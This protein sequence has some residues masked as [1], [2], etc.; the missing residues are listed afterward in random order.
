M[1]PAGALLAGKAVHVVDILPG[2]HHQ[3]IGGDQLAA[4]SA[5][6]SGT[7]QPGQSHYKETSL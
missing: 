5:V 6:A 4:G 3:L 2:P 7:K 1:P